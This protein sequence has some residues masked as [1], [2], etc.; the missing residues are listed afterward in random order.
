MNNKTLIGKNN[1][2]FLINDSCRELD[3]H[4]NNLNLVND[5]T[6]SKYKFKN[7]MII[8]F[9]NKS[10]IYKNYLPQQYIIKYRPA[11]DIYKNVLCDKVIDTYDIL[12]N[13]EDVYY[14]TDTHINIKGGYIVYKYFVEQLNKVYNLDI[15]HK[16]I[17]IISKKC[18]LNDLQLGIG[19]LLWTNNLGN[20]T[21]IDK[22][23]TFYYSNDFKYIYCKH[24]IQPNDEIRLLCKHTLTDLNN[25]L[26]DNLLSWDVLSKY[27]LY[28][29]NT[30][31][32][33]LKVLIF[34]DS[35]LTSVLDLYLSLFNEVYMVKDIYNDKIINMISPDFVFEFRV[36]RFLF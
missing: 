16:Q 26:T 25:H 31:T 13:E 3:V 11:L 23:D 21:V 19:D 30:S 18:Y 32:N 20:Q 35:F 24:F 6:L 7:F 22:I 9:P 34:Y 27:I 33:K 4:C 17:E 1:Y 14:K 8:I 2:L 15:Q 12:K 28:K 29:K 36:E 5:N 10:L